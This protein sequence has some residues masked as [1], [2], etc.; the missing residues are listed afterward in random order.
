MRAIVI[1][2]IACLSFTTHFFSSLLRFRSCF[3]FIYLFFTNFIFIL[4]YDLWFLYFAVVS[5]DF[6]LKNYSL[7]FQFVRANRPNE[8]DDHQQNGSTVFLVFPIFCLFQ[9]T[10]SWTNIEMKT[11]RCSWMKI[12]LLLG[13][14]NFRLN[15][16]IFRILS[17][18]GKLSRISVWFVFF[19]HSSSFQS[20]SFSWLS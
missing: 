15:D 13:P 3:C 20:R 11:T 14:N 19:F 4:V 12:L 18:L 5:S 8:I 1:A 2:S 10:E 16:E 6:P 7:W 9:C 17:N